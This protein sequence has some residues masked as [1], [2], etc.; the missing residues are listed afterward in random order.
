MQGTKTRM[1]LQNRRILT[2]T[3]VLIALSF[4][5]RSTGEPP[6]VDSA[7]VQ[8]ELRTAIAG[9]FDLE[10]LKDEFVRLGIE[11]AKTGCADSDERLS[12]GPTR[13]LVALTDSAKTSFLIKSPKFQ[14][15]PGGSGGE[16]V[17]V[18]GVDGPAS[19]LLD[20][21]IHSERAF[22]FVE[23]IASPDFASC[24]V[25]DAPIDLSQKDFVYGSFEFE[26]HRLDD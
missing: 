3:L 25:L 24:T 10:E 2:F 23:T 8:T 20:T 13:L 4:S 19:T 5:C 6:E 12:G 22:I 14:L 21:Q 11:V 1:L 7:S 16:P 18:I 15:G 26:L 9:I 17:L